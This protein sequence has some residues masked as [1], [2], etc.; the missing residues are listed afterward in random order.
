MEVRFNLTLD[1]F[2][3]F[4]HYGEAQQASTRPRRQPVLLYAAAVLFVLFLILP[5]VLGTP[6]DLSL[7]DPKTVAVLVFWAAVVLVWLLSVR[8]RHIMPRRLFEAARARGL[9]DDNVVSI[10]ADRLTHTNKGGTSS[11]DWSAV[12]EVGRTP[13]YIVIMTGDTTGYLIPRR[14][15]AS[16]ADYAG[17]WE[18]AQAY[19][20]AQMPQS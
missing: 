8:A 18:A 11:T 20:Q 12:Q 17:F 14:A 4:Q 13:E 15:F 9:V 6:P 19:H 3:A 16:D 10:S 2:L 7:S 5:F 1:D